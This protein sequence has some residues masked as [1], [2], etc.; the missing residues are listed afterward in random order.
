M[1]TQST[2]RMSG[3]EF[4]VIGVM[5]LTFILMVVPSVFGYYMGFHLH[6]AINWSMGM[7]LIGILT[8]IWAMV[9]VIAYLLA[10]NL[11]DGP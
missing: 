1:A 10:Q 3:S 11:P 2:Q 4:W 9:C 8:A 6:M 5:T 7:S